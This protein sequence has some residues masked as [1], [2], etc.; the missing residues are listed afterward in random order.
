MVRRKDVIQCLRVSLFLL[1]YCM[2]MENIAGVN[3][4]GRSTSCQ[5]CIPIKVM[6]FHFMN[7][8]II[9][10]S[11]AISKHHATILVEKDS[12]FLQDNNSKN[13]TRRS[14]VNTRKGRDMLTTDTSKSKLTHNSENSQPYLYV[15]KH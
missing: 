9:G 1:M 15:E 10:C 6:S 13:H 7:E 12:H 2:P 5:I 11:Q 14:K 8:C 4:V 3:T